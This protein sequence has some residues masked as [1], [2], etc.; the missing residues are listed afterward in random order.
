[1]VE[2]D[3]GRALATEDSAPALFTATRSSRVG[4]T[5]GH[6]GTSIWRCSGV[7][8]G[9]A[10]ASVPRVPQERSTQFVNTDHRQGGDYGHRPG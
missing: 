2:F 1:M 8:E 9:L 4:I 3:S 7:V 5:L 10:T 6:N